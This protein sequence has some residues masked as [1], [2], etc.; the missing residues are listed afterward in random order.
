MS[1][2]DLLVLL[3][4]LDEIGEVLDQQLG[5]LP[6]VLQVG[7]LHGDLQQLGVPPQPD[8]LQ[9]RV[10]PDVG[11]KLVLELIGR[12]VQALKGRVEEVEGGYAGVETEG[13][14]LLSRVFVAGI[15]R[16]VMDQLKVSQSVPGEDQIGEAGETGVA[17]VLAGEAEGVAV[18]TVLHHLLVETFLQAVAEPFDLAAP[19][20]EFLDGL[21]DELNVDLLEGVARD[22]QLG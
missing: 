17:A 4:R 11:I 3:R 16:A 5:E 14:F 18:A 12:E 22:F 13:V 19:G 1:Q 7:K 8:P 15:Q 20:R 9:V 6:R 2:A 21:G 10:V